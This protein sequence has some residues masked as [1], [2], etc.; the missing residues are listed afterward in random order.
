M[1]GGEPGH[2]CGLGVLPTTEPPSLAHLPLGTARSYC[3]LTLG[4]ISETGFPGTS[5]SWPQSRPLEGSN[6]CS[7]PARGSSSSG[8]AATVILDIPA[9]FGDSGVQS[10]FRLDWAPLKAEGDFCLPVLLVSFWS[11]PYLVLCAIIVCEGLW[12]LQWLS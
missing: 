3:V 9:T 6:H 2:G 8:C 11:S 7:T 5:S 4:V 1:G 10:G 12:R